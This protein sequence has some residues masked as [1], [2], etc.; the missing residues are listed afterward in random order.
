MSTDLLL[1]KRML[2]EGI[3]SKNILG[4]KV[5]NVCAI[6]KKLVP[7]ISAHDEVAA[8]L[9]QHLEQYKGKS[10]DWRPEI[11]QGDLDVFRYQNQKI[12]GQRCC[13]GIWTCSG[14]HQLR[15]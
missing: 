5:E 13:K 14:T 9:E 2:E 8:K 3:R 15:S 11:L 12:G 4:D 6:L 7:L 10:K 1:V